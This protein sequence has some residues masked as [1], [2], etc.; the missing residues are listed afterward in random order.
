MRGSVNLPDKA[1]QH[2]DTIG[3]GKSSSHFFG[4][5]EPLIEYSSFAERG[6]GF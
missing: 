3:M 4:V 5:C 2:C 1:K 6:E